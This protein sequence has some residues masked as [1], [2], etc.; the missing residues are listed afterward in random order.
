MSL[1]T[2]APRTWS[3]L[4]DRSGTHLLDPTEEQ[5]SSVLRDLFHG[6][7]GDEPVEC[8]L[9][10]GQDGAS[11]VHVAFTERRQAHL[12]E[13]VSHGAET[14]LRLVREASDVSDLEALLLWRRLAA[15]D[16][17]TVRTWRWREV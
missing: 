15:G 4:T 8:A 11:V 16:V 1:P 17:D 2:P 10:Y 7:R 6:A 14:E 3:L 12:E 13:W 9:E 5:R